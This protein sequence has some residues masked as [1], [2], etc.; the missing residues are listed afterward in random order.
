MASAVLSVEPPEFRKNRAAR[1]ATANTVR[2]TTGT[3]A[4]AWRLSI[5]GMV[6]CTPMDELKIPLDSS[7]PL[8][9]PKNID[10]LDFWKTV[11]MVLKVKERKQSLDDA[12]RRKNHFGNQ[13]SRRSLPGRPF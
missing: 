3:A 13:H 4:D 2:I 1:N 10:P 5:P 6:T 9:S 11:M 7:A 12:E 8:N